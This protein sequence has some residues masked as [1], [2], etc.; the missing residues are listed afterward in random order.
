MIE[1]TPV[2]NQYR[3][4]VRHL[5]NT[6]FLKEVSEGEDIDWDLKDLYNNIASQLFDAVVLYP[7]DIS[8]AKL[9]PDHIVPKVP[10]AF[11]QIMP[12]DHAAA[13]VLINREIDSGYWDEKATDQ[14]LCDSRMSFLGFFDFDSSGFMEMNYYLVLIESAPNRPDLAGRQA[15]IPVQ[16][17]KAYFID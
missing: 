10:L 15:L 5:Y 16:Y 14:E 2:I 6:Y 17:A 8:N 4:C 12:S 3:E 11:L 7:R 9:T 13:M 1:I